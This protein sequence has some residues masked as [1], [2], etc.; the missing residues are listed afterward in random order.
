M[1]LSNKLKR[2]AHPKD[3]IENPEI[4][5]LTHQM[6]SPFMIKIN[7]PK[8]MMVTGMV[9]K[10]S[11]GFKKT[12]KRVKINAT[13]IAVEKLFISAPGKSLAVAQI[14]MLNTINTTIKFIVF[15]LVFPEM[16]I[17][18]SPFSINSL[19]SICLISSSKEP[20]FTDS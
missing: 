13:I 3:W 4:S 17:T 10:T 7:K 2:I 1:I 9:S 15:Y 16:M 14:E 5:P 12:L 18:N 19:F 11:K 20:L 8:V 6:I